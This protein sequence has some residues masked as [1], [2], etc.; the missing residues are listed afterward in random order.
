MGEVSGGNFSM[1]NHTLSKH[2]CDFNNGDVSSINGFI[3]SHTIS[4]YD[5]S[6]KFKKM[7]GDV[8]I[9]TIFRECVVFHRK[10]TTTHF[11]HFLNTINDKWIKRRR[12]SNT[13]R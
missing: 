3:N 9:T 1:K 10:I 11:T 6:S 4:Q 5:D 12:I 8:E 13:C 7:D 2:G